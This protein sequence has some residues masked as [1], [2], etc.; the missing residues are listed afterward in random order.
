MYLCMCVC[1]VLR[2]MPPLFSSTIICIV[3]PKR[4]RSGSPRA[5]KPL[6]GRAPHQLWCLW[7]GAE[8]EREMVYSCDGGTNRPA[9]LSLKTPA[10]PFDTLSIFL[11]KHK[12]HSTPIHSL[13]TR[14]RPL[15]THSPS[16]PTHTSPSIWSKQVRGSQQ[17]PSHSPRDSLLTKT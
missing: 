7:W 2:C 3:C 9:R 5:R 17:T 6:V 4:E 16:Q 8:S 10:Q 14:H 1:D 15:Y 13:L 11:T 12:P